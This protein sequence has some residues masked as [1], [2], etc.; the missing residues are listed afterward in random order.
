MKTAYELRLMLLLS[1]LASTPASRSQ[2]VTL[3]QLLIYQHFGC[4]VWVAAFEIAV[5]VFAT[6]LRFLCASGSTVVALPAAFV[7]LY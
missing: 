7:V 2:H 1:L 3:P 4:C 5:T 6:V